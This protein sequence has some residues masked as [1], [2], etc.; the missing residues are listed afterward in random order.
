MSL[1]LAR[2]YRGIAFTCTS[3]ATVAMQPCWK[4]DGEVWNSQHLRTELQSMCIPCHLNRGKTCCESC[5]EWAEK[6]SIRYS[7]NALL[8]PT[9]YIL[10]L[11]KAFTKDDCYSS[12]SMGDWPTH[13]WNS[14][15]S[16]QLHDRVWYITSCIIMHVQ[17]LQ[18]H[19]SNGTG[20]VRRVLTLL[21]CFH[22][23]TGCNSLSHPLNLNWFYEEAAQK[24]K[25]VFVYGVLPEV[26]H[27]ETGSRQLWCC[28]S[29]LTN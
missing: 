15:C 25:H 22:L 24:V 16:S 29:S 2:L 11:G 27:K 7:K 9:L 20:L 1:I 8:K 26:V 3:L 5:G 13:Q 17:H 6:R 19:A 18:C 28:P 12:H 10:S 14:C 4:A 21:Q 23:A